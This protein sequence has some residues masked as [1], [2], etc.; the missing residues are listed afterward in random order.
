MT[1]IPAQT[2]TKTAFGE[3][4]TAEKTPQVQVRFPYDTVPYDLVQGLYNKSGSTIT[5][6][7]GNCVV[8]CSSTAQSIS[9]IRSVD[10]VR[11]SPGQG[12]EFLGTCVFTT[13]VANSSQIVGMG[14]D[15]EGYFFGYNGV[16]FGI[17]RRSSG[18]L[19]IKS[20]TITGGADGD[21]GD[22]T[23]T[24]DG[25][26]VTITVSA[27]DT[28]AEVVAAIVA[29]SDDFLHAGRGWEVHTED[30]VSVEFVSL[31]AE[32]AAGS[33][34]FADVD[35]GVTAG[36]F[37]TPVTGVAPTDNW[38]LQADWNVDV[39][40]GS[41]KSGMTL[42]PTKG[43]IYRIQYQYLGYGSL[44][45][46]VEDADTGDIAPVHNLQYANRN[47]V[48]TLQ[49]PTLHA[50]LI[51]KTETGYSGGALT[52]KSSSLSGFTQGKVSREGIRRSISQEKS[53]T[54]TEQVIMILHNELDFNG[55]HNK[56]TVWPDFMSF[57]SESSKTTTL[58]LYKNPTVITGGAALTPIESGVSV[59]QTSQTGSTISGGA[60][61]LTMIFNGGGD[62][63]L[64]QFAAKIRPGERYVIT[65]QLSSGAASLV[66]VSM[67]WVERV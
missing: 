23:I 4:S 8:T 65:G 58:R 15:D 9:Q 36:A 2:L 31:I 47:I 63:N 38:V 52:M 25:D 17:L 7:D 16:D 55:K 46:C 33:F 13:G 39:M 40:D 53:M 41:G 5:T 10:T 57:G 56:I 43:N 60:R 42:D 14:D 66:D 34:S 24:L 54:T 62:R 48:P 12:V 51:A 44:C 21:G 45:F 59:M 61:L 26:A 19:E 11:Y 30:N 67:T 50:T 27:S 49:D 20:L 22:F 35:S 29:A 3:L 37:S 32:S 1:Y 18:S 28:V 64:A 6:S